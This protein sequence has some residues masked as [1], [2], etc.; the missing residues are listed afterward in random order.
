[1]PSIHY[2]DHILSFMVQYVVI[3]QFLN[4]LF[5]HMY[6]NILGQWANVAIGLKYLKVHG[7]LY[8]K[9]KMENALNKFDLRRN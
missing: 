8:L 3:L 4:I 9:K 2:D 5:M 6:R 1:M 7:N